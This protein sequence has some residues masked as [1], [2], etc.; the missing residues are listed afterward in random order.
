MLLIM[1]FPDPGAST[2]Q[3]SRWQITC[4]LMVFC[5]CLAAGAQNNPLPPSTISPA[6]T[7]TTDL[8]LTLQTIRAEHNIPCISLSWI[9]DQ[10][11]APGKIMLGCHTDAVLRWGSITK[12]VTAL[13]MLDLALAGQLDLYAPISTYLDDSLWDNAW[14]ADHPIRVIDLL[15]LRS[16]FTD[17]SPRAFNYNQSMPLTEAL[18]FEREQLRAYWPPGL[19]HAYSNLTPGLSELLIETITR[20]TFAEAVQARVFKPLQLHNASFT[21]S[22]QLLPGFQSDGITPLPYWQMTFAA[23]GALN[24]ST[25]DMQKLLAALLQ[26]T[27]LHKFVHQHLRRPHGRRYLPQFRFDYAA[28][29]YP[30]VR[31][32]FVW[33]N[34]GGDADGYR[35][36]LS[37]M[38]E[39][40]R[41]Y[42]ANITSDNPAALRAIE[43]AIEGYLTDDLA[44]PVQPAELTLT[45]AQLLAFTG[46]YYPSGTRFGL[47]AWQAG[48]LQGVEVVN[49]QGQL[50]LIRGSAETR[51]IAVATNQ[52]RRIADP[53]ATVAF[54]QVGE[55]LYLQGELGNYAR[56]RNCP[57]FLNC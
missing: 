3:R 14:R 18:R 25:A 2:D 39:H 35:S 43:R 45:H 1:M 56:R 42:V 5:S 46:T 40:Q 11:A 57:T 51:L 37:I 21:Q 27:I 29:F 17:L 8:Q 38:A 49:R 10:P 24:A 52:F 15:E 54:V 41:G 55:Q 53:A 4:W 36:R 32:G 26:P 44:P 23:F 19:Q 12:T 30:R 16:G 22:D 7:T 13:T 9:K 20:Q 28:G 34:H 48:K 50:W 6:Q 33:H 47:A 31:R